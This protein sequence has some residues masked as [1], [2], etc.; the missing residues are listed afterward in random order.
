MVSGELIVILLKYSKNLNYDLTDTLIFF[1]IIKFEYYNL[2]KLKIKNIH[3]FEAYPMYFK[4]LT[5][6]EIVE[7]HYIN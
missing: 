5:V 3:E 1:K 7:F 6:I 4:I 2:K